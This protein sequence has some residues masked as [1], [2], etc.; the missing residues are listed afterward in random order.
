[1]RQAPLKER[2]HAAMTLTFVVVGVIAL[3]WVIS[4]F[5]KLGRFSESGIGEQS[6]ERDATQVIQGPYETAP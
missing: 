2:K 6:A 3:V 4:L 1:M 5:F